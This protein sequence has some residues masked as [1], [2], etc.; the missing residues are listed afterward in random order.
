MITSSD[1]EMNDIFIETKP[2]AT[3]GHWC[4]QCECYHPN[5][6]Y[7]KPSCTVAG[8]EIIYLKEKLG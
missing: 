4:E 7:T 2:D 5:I 8:F 6:I 1:Y 3:N